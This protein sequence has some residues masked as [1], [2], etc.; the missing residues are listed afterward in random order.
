ME[1]DGGYPISLFEV[2][3]MLHLPRSRRATPTPDLVYH[4][5]S[6]ARRLVTRA[7]DSGHTYT[8]TATATNSLGPSNDQTEDGKLVLFLLLATCC[9]FVFMLLLL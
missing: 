4:V 1:F 9:L 8:I 3:V 6:S 2:H 5:D 7:V